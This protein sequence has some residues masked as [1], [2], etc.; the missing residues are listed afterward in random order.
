MPPT[1]SLTLANRL[2]EIDRLITA[3][4]AFGADAGVSQD[5]I[6]R[7]SVSL[8]EIVTNVI[9]HAFGSADGQQ[10]IVRVS[11]DH[12]LVTAVVDD[13]GLPFDPLSVPPPDLS[14]SLEDRPIGGLGLHLV[15]SLTQSVTYRRDGDRN[16][17]TIT[18]GPR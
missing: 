17:L 11:V 14:A 18:V 10:I 15:R 7:L 4:E 12:E 2:D 3:L 1:L 6:F 13:D 8:D 5:V 16:V 9:R